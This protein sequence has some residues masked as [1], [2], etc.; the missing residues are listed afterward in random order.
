MLDQNYK[1]R[2]P[3]RYDN[4]STGSLMYKNARPKPQDH[5]STSAWHHEK[6]TFAGRDNYSC[7]EVVCHAKRVFLISPPKLQNSKTM[8]PQNHNSINKT[9]KARQDM[10]ARTTAQWDHK[11]IRRMRKT[12]K[13]NTIITRVRSQYYNNSIS[14]ITIPQQEHNIIR[15]TLELRQLFIQPLNYK[16]ISKID[17]HVI[18]S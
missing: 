18:I 1:T 5:A 11:F 17:I 6:N 8:R 14:E 3:Q 10:R 2:G 12:E 4:K 9:T 7:M 15:G 13:Y 16:M